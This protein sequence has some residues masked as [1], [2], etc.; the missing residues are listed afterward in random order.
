MLA[1]AMGAT[2]VCG[3]DPSPQRRNLALQMGAVDIALD[4]QEDEL[5]DTLGDG[6]EVAIDCSGNGAGQLSALR[7]T[8]RWGRVALVGEGGRLTVDV[9]EVLIHRQLT[10]YGS[11]VSSTWRMSELLNRLVTWNLH[12]G[13]LVTDTFNLEEAALAYNV[14]DTARHGKVGFVWQ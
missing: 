14:A 3:T 10:V 2:S 5:K 6:A 11:W 8:R 13:K 12:P 7:N 1:K 9:S 4:G